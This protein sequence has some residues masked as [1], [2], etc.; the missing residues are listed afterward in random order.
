MN[1]YYVKRNDRLPALTATLK[2]S[3]GA[4]VNLSAYT[5]KFHMWLEGKAAKVNAAAVVVSAAAGTVRYDWAAGDT[6]TAG[7][8][9]CEWEA[10][11][12]TSKQVTFPNYENDLV[13]VT[14]DAE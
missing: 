10:T 7:E 6:D 3:A 1:T 12:V 8:Y 2:D 13:I 11:D 5:V 14:A 9:N 4:A